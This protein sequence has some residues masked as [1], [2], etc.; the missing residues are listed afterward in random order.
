M[1]LSVYNKIKETIKNNALRLEIFPVI[2]LTEITLQGQKTRPRGGAG[3]KKL[4][5][6]GGVKKPYR[7][8][9]GTVALH[10]MRYQKSTELLIRK[11]PFARCVF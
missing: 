8:R 9:P 10:D 7:Y 11:R 3:K 1:E 5:A 4:P 2:F 6:T